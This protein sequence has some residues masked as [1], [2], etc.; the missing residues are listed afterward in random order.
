M[1]EFIALV[2]EMFPSISPYTAEKALSAISE[3]FKDKRNM[4]FCTSRPFDFLAQGDIFS[5]MIFSYTDENG[6]DRSLP[7]KGILLSNTCDSERD[8]FILFAPML[9]IETYTSQGM[10]KASIENNKYTK[11]LFIPS[12]VID[13][14]V[15]DLSVVNAFSRKLILKLLD[16]EM[17]TKDAT[18]NLWG[19]YLYLSKLTVHLMRPEDMEANSSRAS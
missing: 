8:E 7:A 16:R 9:P 3:N 2:Q 13:N 11:L 15:V 1:N 6:E 19:Y 12:R 5:G 10:D 4:E 17:V 18:L 14:H